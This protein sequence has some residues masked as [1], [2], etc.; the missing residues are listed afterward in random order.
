[1]QSVIQKQRDVQDLICRYEEEVEK[2][3]RCAQSELKLE[4][5]F[6][7]IEESWNEQVC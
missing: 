3:V 2:I 5:E 4:N 7:A 6:H 1:M